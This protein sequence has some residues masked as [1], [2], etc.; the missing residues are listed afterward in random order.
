MPWKFS[1]STVNGEKLTQNTNQPLEFHSKHSRPFN[2]PFNLQDLRISNLL[3]LKSPDVPITSS[4][5]WRRQICRWP[6]VGWAPACPDPTRWPWESDTFAGATAESGAASACKLTRVEPTKKRK[7]FPVGNLHLYLF[8]REFSGLYLVLIYVNH[9]YVTNVY[10]CVSLCIYVR[11]SRPSDSP[12]FSKNCSA[13]QRSKRARRAIQL[14][15]ETWDQACQG[16][17]I[18]APLFLASGCSQQ[19]CPNPQDPRWPKG[20]EMTPMD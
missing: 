5:F 8:H 6:Q 19:P 9:G 17:C 20:E 11:S 4:S 10:H 1:G 14:Y 13:H 7:G 16:H 15:V 18:L 3:P 2:R 12:N